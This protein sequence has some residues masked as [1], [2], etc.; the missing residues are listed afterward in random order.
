MKR[1]I[2]AFIAFIILLTLAVTPAFAEEIT[3]DGQKASARLSIE[4][5]ILPPDGYTEDSY[6]LYIADINAL[7]AAVDSAA[8]EAALNAIDVETAIA[9]ATAK[10]LTVEQY[11]L[12]AVKEIIKSAI[13]EVIKPAELYTE[14]SYALY[15]ADINA[16]IAII[17]GA[18][19]REA[20]DGIDADSV[21][22]AAEEK[23]V[24]LETAKALADAKSAALASLGIK[25]KNDGKIYTEESYAAYSA[26]YEKIAALI[27][28]ISSI[29][30]LDMLDVDALAVEAEH[31]LV[32]A[33]RTEVEEADEDEETV[34]RET[35][36]P[37]AD[38][39]EI[40]EPT[41]NGCTSTV[42]LSALA[43]IGLMGTAL[44]FKRRA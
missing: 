18:E 42:A 41:S 13:Q 22:T 10:L 44:T 40:E 4:E 2:S 37:K 24:T 29:E 5:A 38:E 39:P 25:H 34:M 28:E 36:A 12:I 7:L 35:D 23:L 26:E 6:A 3:L 33:V 1:I 8:D 32:I 30:V 16:F 15:I 19:S 14:D 21:I 27:N 11:E 43:V 20:L 17:D 31:L 9:S